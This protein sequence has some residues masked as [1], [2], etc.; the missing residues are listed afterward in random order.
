MVDR[1]NDRIQ[2]FGIGGNFILQWGTTGANDGQF[3]TPRGIAVNPTTGEVY[4]AD[5]GNHRIQKFGPTGNFLTKW[6]SLGSADGQ[7][8]SADFAAID[9]LGDVY[10]T[11]GGTMLAYKNSI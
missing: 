2:K 11:D 9:A 7:F 8:H 1:N 6:G 3:S 5:T 10:V 4:V